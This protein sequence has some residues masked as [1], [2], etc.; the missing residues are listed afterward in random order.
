M[1]Q[2]TAI[3][4]ADSTLNLMMGCDGCELRN[5]QAG[6]KICYAG[7]LVDRYGGQKGYPKTF[8]E[9]ELFLERLEPALK[10]KDL[11]GKE[12]PDK[13]WLNGLPR[14]V[15]L[16]DMG[17]T[18]TESLP[19]D[20]LAPLLPKLAAS[21]HIFMVLTK[22]PTRMKLFAEAYPLPPNVWPG[23]TVTSQKTLRRVETLLRVK[24]GGVKWV[25]AE[26]LWEGV[27]IPIIGCPACGK[28]ENAWAP[29]F[30]IC[31]A[32]R[33]EI[34]YPPNRIGLV[35]VG[36]ES[37]RTTNPFN[38][39][40]ARSII[41]D[42]KATETACFIKQLGAV[43]YEDDS[44]LTGAPVDTS[45]L[46]RLPGAAMKNR[47]GSDMSEWPADLQIRQFPRVE[48]PA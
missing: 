43:P 28:S 24:S 26:P 38:I 37:G 40:W 10:W 48:V 34:A 13:P 41:A 39:A 31:R 33:E 5:L 17:D 4:W 2:N 35:I 9:P 29:N 7:E 8:E 45:K 1:S 19:F 25:S 15:F 12:R 42:C 27:K 46:T 14:V 20:W 21:P 3:E 44:H 23:V 30:V 11:T 6:V 36:G 32:C 18:F 16:N 22:R 47:K